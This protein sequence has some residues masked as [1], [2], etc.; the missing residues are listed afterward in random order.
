MLFGYKA[1]KCFSLPGEDSYLGEEFTQAGINLL[2]GVLSRAQLLLEERAAR[3]FKSIGM[4]L[5]V[6]RYRVVTLRPEN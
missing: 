3:W 5:L 4:F 6:W 1:L 2:V